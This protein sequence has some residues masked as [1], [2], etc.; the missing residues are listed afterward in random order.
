MEEKRD[1]Q[2]EERLNQIESRLKTIQICLYILLGW[3]FLIPIGMGLLQMVFLQGVY[4]VMGLVIVLA[5]VWF[6][7]IWLPKWFQDWE[8]GN[9]GGERVVSEFAESLKTP[10]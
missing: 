8:Q 10:G 7:V 4:G 1:S 5:A 9:R 3:V 6:A 2:T